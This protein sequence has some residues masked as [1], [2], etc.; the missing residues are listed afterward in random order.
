MIAPTFVIDLDPKLCSD[1]FVFWYT[2]GKSMPLNAQGSANSQVWCSAAPK[3]IFGE[4]HSVQM[5]LPS[6]TGSKTRGTKEVWSKCD[7]KEMGN[8]L[9][10]AQVA[11]RLA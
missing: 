9:L 8:G 3:K 1:L 7:R 2:S 5:H 4:V 6:A 11:S 10:S